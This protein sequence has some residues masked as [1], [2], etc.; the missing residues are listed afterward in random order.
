MKGKA[1]R[2]ISAFCQVRSLN[3]SWEEIIANREDT[4]QA[5]IETLKKFKQDNQRFDYQFEVRNM[6]QEAKDENKE[7]GISDNDD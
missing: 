2:E 1:D 7:S 5:D 6:K 3:E 4:F